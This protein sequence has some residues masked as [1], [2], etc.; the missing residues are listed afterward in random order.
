[1]QN[2]LYKSTNNIKDLCTFSPLI[3]YFYYV[4]KYLNPSNLLKQTDL[5]QIIRS[6]QNNHDE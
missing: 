6:A 4:F 2:I 5:Y 1:M 3:D